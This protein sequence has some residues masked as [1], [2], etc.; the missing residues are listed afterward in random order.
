MDLK[1]S[2]PL[3]PHSFPQSSLSESCSLLGTGHVRG[4]IC[5]GN[6]GDCL[7]NK[8]IF[9]CNF[10][11]ELTMYSATATGW[12][13]KFCTNY[14]VLQR[15]KSIARTKRDS[16]LRYSTFVIMPMEILSLLSFLAKN[17][18]RLSEK[19]VDKEKYFAKTYYPRLN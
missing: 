2:K 14:F 5:T 15:K 16:C 3:V 8:V 12:T 13:F 17:I 6:G 1:F 11:D 4:R 7:C 10:I 18:C 19:P 9:F